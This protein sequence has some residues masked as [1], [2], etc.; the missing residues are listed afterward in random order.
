M[1]DN[2]KHEIEEFLN[3]NCKDFS[4]SF[5]AGD[6][7]P[8]KYYR[9]KQNSK[10]FVLMDAS[11]KDNDLQP[12]I[13]MTNF[14]VENNFSAPQIIAEDMEW[15]FLLLEDLGDNTYNNALKKEADEFELYKAATD[16]LIKLHNISIPK[17]LN[18]HEDEQLEK[19]E[20]FLQWYLPY[21]N[22]E[23]KEAETEFMEIWQ[24]YFNEM[25][26]DRVVCLYDY[27]ADNLLWLEN[28]KGIK[29]VGLLDYQDAVIGPDAIDLAALLQD[30]RRE[31]SKDT[32][33]RILKYFITETE[34]DA[35]DFIKQYFFWGVHWNTRILGTF[36]R[37]AKRDNKKDYLNYI[38]AVWNR[39]EQDLEHPYMKPLKDWFN[40]YI[41]EEMRNAA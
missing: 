6:A 35:E 13:F 1:T 32:Q 2:R 21:I 25:T 24:K 9:V 3:K 14:L 38:P 41:P 23:N 40:K 27:H 5:L 37:L 29:N 18:K 28:R 20:R 7:S 39:L 19:V 16:I 22:Y 33:D 8:R 15:G 34:K 4:Y 31:V 36:A 17:Q 10:T 26:D 30:I 11:I 12:F